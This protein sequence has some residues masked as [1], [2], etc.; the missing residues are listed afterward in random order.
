MLVHYFDPALWTVATFSKLVQLSP[1][2][3]FFV[4]ISTRIQCVRG[5]YRVLGL[6][7]INTCRKVPLQVKFFRSRHFALPSMSLIFLR[8]DLYLYSP[9][10]ISL[11]VSLRAIPWQNHKSDWFHINGDYCTYKTYH[12]QGQRT[13]VKIIVYN[14]ANTYLTI[15]SRKYIF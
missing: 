6:R 1:P 14:F 12:D 8:Q 5:G 2:P 3:P 4:W 15:F 7:Q 11:I 10:S 13:H 9:I